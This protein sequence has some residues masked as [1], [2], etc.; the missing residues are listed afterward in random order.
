MYQTASS[1]SGSAPG[2]TSLALTTSSAQSSQTLVAPQPPRISHPQGIPQSVAPAKHD[3]TNST[4][5][6]IYDQIENSL[7]DGYLHADSYMA[8]ASGQGMTNRKALQVLAQIERK[9]SGYQGDKPGDQPVIVKKQV[10][11][12]IEEATD[13]RNLAQGYVLGWMPHW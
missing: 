5:L 13:I 12:L 11:E 7:I 8:K 2:A 1:P 10:Q 9:M 6:E 4:D 3:Y